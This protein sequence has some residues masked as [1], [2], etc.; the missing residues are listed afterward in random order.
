M[1]QR[2]YALSGPNGPDSN[3]ADNRYADQVASDLKRHL[4]PTAHVR[5]DLLPRPVQFALL[6]N[7]S[8][9]LV[10]PQLIA[11]QLNDPESTLDDLTW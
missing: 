1:F 10:S 5:Y 3:R 11:A 9:G 2:R 7:I 8:D 6:A 4:D